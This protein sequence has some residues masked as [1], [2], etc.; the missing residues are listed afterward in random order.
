MDQSTGQKNIEASYKFEV[1][2]LEKLFHSASARI[3]DFLLI[4]R[5]FDYS[6]ADIARKIEMTPKTVGKEISI[7]LELGA[8]K[9]TRKSGR[10]NMFRINDSQKVRGLLQYVNGTQEMMSYPKRC[11]EMPDIIVHNAQEELAFRKQYV[12]SDSDIWET[13]M[14]CQ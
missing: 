8:I 4:Y 12:S 5:D 11:K 1:R 13:V 9:L 14:E 7:L 3:I 2:P 10:S 6:E